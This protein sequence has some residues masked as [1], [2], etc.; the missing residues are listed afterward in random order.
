M[1]DYKLRNPKCWDDPLVHFQCKIRI[2]LEQNADLVLRFTRLAQD[3]FVSFT[4]CT[5]INLKLVLEG[6]QV[7]IWKSVKH[8]SYKK[9]DF[10]SNKM[11]FELEFSFISKVIKEI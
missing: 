2:L 3:T 8:E 9:L 10:L 6:V 11:E 4:S 5:C 1:R 7:G